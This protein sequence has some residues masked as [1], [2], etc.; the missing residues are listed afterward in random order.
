M[1]KTKS[2]KKYRQV[3]LIFVFMCSISI[4]I[5]CKDTKTMIDEKTVT[6][7]VSETLTEE[8]TDIETNT[9]TATEI[10]PIKMIYSDSDPLE[11]DK[12]SIAINKIKCCGFS[13]YS[14]NID[15][16]LLNKEYV[17]NE[18]NVKNVVLT[19]LS[20]E[21]VYTT[22]Y[23]ENVTLEAELSGKLRFTSTIPSSIKEDNYKLYFE[24]NSYK[25][26]LCLFE[27]PY[28]LREDRKVN[29][30]IDGKLVKTDITKHKKPINFIFTYDFLDGMSHCN[31]WYTDEEG[32]NEF[33]MDTL[34]TSDINLYGFEE[35]NYN[36]LNLD[37]HVYSYINDIIYV[38]NDGILVIPDEYWDQEVRIILYMI[39][40]LNIT[41]L[42]IPKAVLSIYIGTI[43]NKE[44]IIYYEG[45]QEEWENVLLEDS[46]EITNQIIFNAEYNR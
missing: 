12:I 16:T 21:A 1:N 24:I 11:E 31:T 30:Y 44:I 45:T 17:T 35:S 28:E 42:H 10:I 3:L 46:G 34:I 15:I 33:E 19:K 37:T 40:K 6:K 13:N 4:L 27:T 2:N 29:Y 18:Y 23:T 9:D 39:D 5:G 25:F 26:V 32:L 36:W 38:P 7:E 22:N 41:E 14:L 43:T 20:T 8:V